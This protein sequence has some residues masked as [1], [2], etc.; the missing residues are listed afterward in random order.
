MADPASG[1]SGLGCNNVIQNQQVVQ[2]LQVVINPA[3]QNAAA[4]LVQ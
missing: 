1:G 3:Q 2:P 4:Q